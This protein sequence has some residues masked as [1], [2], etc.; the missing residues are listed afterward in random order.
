MATLPIPPIATMTPNP[1]LTPKSF[2]IF[3]RSISFSISPTIHNTAFAAHGLPHTYTILESASIDGA[4]V[5]M[6]HKLHV[7]KYCDA[8]SETARVIRAVNTLVVSET[9]T[10]TEDAKKPR[11][12]LVIGAGGAARAA[13][14]ALHKAGVEEMYLVNRTL[15]TAEAVSADFSALFDIHVLPALGNLPSQSQCDKA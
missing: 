6:P 9:K 8:L 12:G 10:E 15:T 3:G 1:D 14:Y 5:T 13:L 7:H 2:Y 4:S 11:V